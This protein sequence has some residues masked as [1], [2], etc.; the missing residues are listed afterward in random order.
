MLTH[1]ASQLNGRLVASLAELSLESTRTPS[2]I[3]SKFNT[4]RLWRNKSDII[5]AR[6]RRPSVGQ[7]EPKIYNINNQT[8]TRKKRVFAIKTRKFECVKWA[9]PSTR[10]LT[11]QPIQIFTIQRCGVWTSKQAS[12][13]KANWKNK[14]PA[15]MR[16]WAEYNWELVPCILTLICSKFCGIR[17]IFIKEKIQFRLPLRH[18]CRSETLTVFFLSRQM[19][20]K[21]APFGAHLISSFHISAKFFH[22]IN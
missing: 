5:H 15:M 16:L 14:T 1:G 9:S 4:W 17:R 8:A 18:V 13:K 3:I 2:R 7:A 12:K 22:Q 10:T 21:A 6:H 19:R 11:T 20:L